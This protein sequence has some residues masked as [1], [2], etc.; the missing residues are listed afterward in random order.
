MA[1]DNRVLIAEDDPVSRLTLQKVL[2]KLEYEVII[3]T[4]G[5]QAWEIAQQSDSPQ[6]MFIDWEMPGMDGPEI[7]KKL[8]EQS[9]TKRYHYKIMLTGKSNKEAIAHALESG[10]DD[11]ISKPFSIAELTARLNVGKRILK[12][13]DKTREQTKQ[14]ARAD[15][16]VS[17]GIMAAGVA[18]EINNPATF[19][20]GNIQILEEMWETISKEFAKVP[21]HER[22]HQISILS[23]EMPQILADMNSG[24]KRITEIV[25]G[26]K[27]FTR[28]DHDKREALSIHHPIKEAIK[29]T[30][31]RAKNGITIK[32]YQE[33]GD[34]LV[35]I[36]SV[37]IEQVLV[38]LL[39]NSIDAIETVSNE[40]CIS[41][42][43]KE[44]N[45]NVVLTVLDS[46]PGLPD[47]VREQLFTPFFTTKEVGKGTGLGL[48]I[49]QH[50]IQD[51]GG[52]I[53][54]TNRAEGGAM[55]TIVLPKSQSTAK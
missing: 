27:S 39:I 22:N 41:I 15:R 30:H 48:S 10:A 18:H 36:N 44:A 42:H 34:L 35:D 9:D 47:S 53:S 52:S 2:E 29:F 6:L 1:F 26:L 50:I 11:Y 20:Y 16:M 28:T 12:M 40:G 49:S 38:N 43:T 23:E 54:V 25:S 24:V 8:T 51:H 21:A 19:I 32:E 37:E 13:Y 46:G 4:D 55:F 31:N 14:L 5:N 45:E 17:M 7:C 33:S 3:A